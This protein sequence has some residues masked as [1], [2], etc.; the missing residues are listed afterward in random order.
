MQNIV[1]QQFEK[2]SLRNAA[3]SVCKNRES[4]KNNV[5]MQN[6]GLN[7]LDYSRCT[8]GDAKTSRWTHKDAT[9][10]NGC[11]LPAPYH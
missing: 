1:K 9:V 11:K 4:C 5:A 6:Y 10:S 7:A 3:K 8:A 2:P